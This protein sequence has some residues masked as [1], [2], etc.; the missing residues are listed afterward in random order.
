[1]SQTPQRMTSPEGRERAQ[2]FYHSIKSLGYDFFTGV[3]CSLL[4]QIYTV[5]DEAG[6]RYIAAPR[7]DLAL[8][9]AAG[10]ALTHRSPV[11]LMQNS[12][13]G[14][15]VNALMSLQQMY[16]LKVLLVV[17]WRGQ[18]P[19]APEHIQMGASTIELL[20]LLRVPYRFALANDA[21]E[22]EFHHEK[23]P[24]VLLVRPHEFE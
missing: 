19:D 13:L 20:E 18:G 21:F 11:I 1:M 4:K 15:C 7:E 24:V 5:I 12:G 22:P 14:V 9:M 2:H 23:G 10:A 16:E 17:S 3:P 8:G 6:E